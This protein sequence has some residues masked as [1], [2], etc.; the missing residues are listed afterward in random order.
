MSDESLFREVDEE[1]RAER[2]KKLW[3]Q[4]GAYAAGAA[5][6]VVLAVAGVKGW[7]YYK[8][9]QA[10]AAGEQYLAAITLINAGKKEEADDALATLA[11][12]NTTGFGALAKFRLAADL[13]QQGKTADAIKAFD[14]IAG[15]DGVDPAMRNLARVRGA[16]L[17]VDS[18]TL[19]QIESRVGSL[20]TAEGPWRYSAREIIAI[21]AFKNGD[22]LK[23]DRLYNELNL[24]ASAPAG[25][26]QRAQLMIGVIS[27][28]LPAAGS[29]AATGDN[30]TSATQ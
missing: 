23:A 10:E 20:N 27:P 8:V 18:E 4:Y 30:Q 5:I 2:F 17:A 25:L 3:Q 13:G 24:D 6:G 29:A 16:L 14:E 21:S 11:K 1:V 28:K 9:Q 19:A 12:E 15:S 7:Q 22:L 26:R